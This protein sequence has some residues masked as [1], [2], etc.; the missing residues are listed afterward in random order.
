[1]NKRTLIILAL[2]WY[3]SILIG[4]QNDYKIASIG[5]YNVENLFDTKDSP[6]TND[7]E[8]TPNGDRAWTDKFYNEKL[9]NLARVISEVGTDLTPDGLSIVGVSEVENRKVLEDL[10][11]QEKIADRNYQIVHYDSPDRRGIDCALLYQEKYFQ[12]TSSKAIPLMIY[13]KKSG[14]RIYTRDV[15]LVSG[16]FDGENLHVLVNH[17]PSR[18]GGEKRTCPLREAG[19]ALCKSISDSLYTLDPNAK[20][21]IMGDLNDDPINTSVKKELKAKKNKE[22]VKLGGMYNAMWDLYS[23][24]FGTLAWRD[25]W[26]LFDQIILSKALIEENQDFPTS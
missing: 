14:K 21:I 12:V 1:M 24:G 19:G 8:F 3:S 5:F 23:K 20:I 4:Q 9:G 26:S 18:S 16:K 22:E 6:N 11:K 10:V 25:S 13:N 15:L 2:F 17:W 7:K